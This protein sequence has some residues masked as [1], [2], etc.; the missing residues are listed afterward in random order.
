MI[1]SNALIFVDD[2]LILVLAT[3]LPSLDFG[4]IETDMSRARKHGATGFFVALRRTQT[5]GQGIDRLDDLI[6]LANHLNLAFIE[7]LRWP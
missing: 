4:K 1:D 3:E 2:S 7:R 6:S 5:A